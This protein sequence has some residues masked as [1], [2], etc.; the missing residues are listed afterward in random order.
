MTYVNFGYGPTQVPKYPL[1]KED[2]LNFLKP[3]SKEVV[4]RPVYIHEHLPP[5]YPLLEGEFLVDSF[6]Y[7]QQTNKFLA[8]ESDNVDVKKEENE[9]TTANEN[10]LQVFKKPTELSPVE[11]FKRPR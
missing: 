1:P 9:D 8:A 3:G 10:N 11:N 6:S 5:M 4:T 2:H 7:I